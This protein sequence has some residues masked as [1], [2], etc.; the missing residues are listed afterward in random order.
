M[1]MCYHYSIKWRYEFSHI[2]TGV[3]TFG[4]TK[5]VHCEAMKERSWSLGNEYVDEIYEYKN[6]V[7]VKTVSVLAF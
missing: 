5:R 3:V 1:K 2:K 6:L 7:V 4:E